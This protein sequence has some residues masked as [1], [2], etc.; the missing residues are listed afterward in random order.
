MKHLLYT[1]FT[2]LVTVQVSAQTSGGPDAFGY[3]WR[4]SNDPNG[5]EFSWI[6]I[7]SVGT[8]VT[9]LADDNA[10]QFI[11]MGGMVFHY[12]WTDITKLIIGSNGW[13]G[14]SPTSN[15]AHCFPTL[16]TSGGAADHYLAPFMTDLLISQSGFEAEVYYYFDES[17]NQFIVSY[18]DVP[19]WNVNSPGY[20]GSNTF[21]VILS[22]EDSSITYQYLDVDQN[23]LNDLTG[24]DQDLVIGL[25]NV[26]GDIGLQVYQE[27]L[28]PD[29]YAIKFY[30]PNPVTYSIQDAGPQWNQNIDNKGQFVAAQTNLNLQAGISNFGNTDINSDV[31]ITATL[32]DLN[33]TT[34]FTDVDTIENLAAGGIT[35][36]VFSEPANLQPGQ[37]SYRTQ[38]QNIDDINPANNLN[39]SELNAVDLNSGNFVLSYATQNAPS[40]SVLWQ[41]GDGGVG[42]YWKPPSYPVYLDSISLY[43]VDFGGSQNFR[44][45]VYDDNLGPN[46]PGDLL[47]SE[48]VSGSTYQTNSWV[49]VPL[50]SPIEVT[51]GGVFLGWIHIFGSTI[52]LGTEQFGPIS[53]QSYELVGGTWTAYR[54]NDN[55][56]FLI[57]GHFTTSCGSFTVNTESIDHVSCFG[58]DDGAIDVTVEGGT[59]PYTYD[60]DN[61]IGAIEDPSGL[62]AGVYQLSVTD[63]EGCNANT[64]ITVNQ[65]SEIVASAIITPSSAGN[66]GAIDL[67]VSGGTP[68]YSYEWSN[69]FFTE[70]V[71]G[72]N[73]GDYTIL[74]TDDNGCEMEFTFTVSDE[75]GIR[76][77]E[78]V[79]LAVFPNPNNGVLTIPNYSDGAEIEV[80]DNLGRKVFLNQ[81]Q[82]TDRVLLTLENASNG[83]YLLIS[84]SENRISRARF[85]IQR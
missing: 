9:G 57:N 25:E 32:S 75:V 67:T 14:F 4:D 15:I 41:G 45:E 38:T 48:I 21:Q 79:E 13:I 10:T 2:F 23:N 54:E 43:I 6:D 29:N 71:T 51:S 8:Q 68:P 47:A 44:V 76:D 73:T 16:P 83:I 77:V 31:I 7:S 59:P 39:T 53:R 3:T 50:P 58:G 33:N 5:P 64:Q 49:T 17:N 46:T 37:Y 60:W 20:V 84:R 1:T 40:G 28:P 74:I 26:T 62:N 80:F 18:I 30:Y 61:A 52:A 81:T 85:V 72:L 34:V 63:D 56:D 19:W 66:S 35:T 11:T 12:Y 65:S 78:L 70:D 82:L 22:A 24:C 42:V 36:S 55:T 69:G 27:Q